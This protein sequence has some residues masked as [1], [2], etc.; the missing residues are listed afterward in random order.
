MI[1][2]ISVGEYQH[3]IWGNLSQSS[4]LAVLYLIFMGSLVGYM[5]YVWLLSVRSPALVGTYAYVN[6]VVA[7]FFG[8]L[9][10]S[11]PIVGKQVIALGVILSGVI[12][13]TLAKESKN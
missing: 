6:P 9:I 7:I 10:A 12:L 2:S 3:E 8:W 13:V 11:E 4:V 1:A 5:S